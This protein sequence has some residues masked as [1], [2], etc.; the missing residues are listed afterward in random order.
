MSAEVD[1]YRYLEFEPSQLEAICRLRKLPLGTYNGMVIAL[2]AQ[3]AEAETEQAVT[4]AIKDAK[5]IRTFMEELTA[6]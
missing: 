4:K 3:E 6:V 1:K 5:V 2:L